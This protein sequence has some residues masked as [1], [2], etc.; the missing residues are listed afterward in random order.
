MKGRLS[1]AH[2][3]NNNPP[4]LIAH[5]IMMGPIDTELCILFQTR[6]NSSI[7]APRATHGIPPICTL[8]PKPL[9]LLQSIAATHLG[10]FLFLIICSLLPS[11]IS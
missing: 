8:F 10:M 6:I 9:H 7:L 2:Y 4:Y 11:F 1:S 3:Y 5:T